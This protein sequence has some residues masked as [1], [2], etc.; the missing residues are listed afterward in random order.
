MSFWAKLKAFI[1]SANELDTGDDGHVVPASN[2]PIDSGNSCVDVAPVPTLDEV[3]DSLVID[4][5]SI[6]NS[7][8]AGNAAAP[9]SAVQTKGLMMF[10]FN[11]TEEELRFI[12]QAVEAKI[13]A[14]Q[15]FLQKLI[16]TANAQ[17]QIQ[18]GQPAAAAN[19]NPPVGEADA[20]PVSGDSADAGAS[21][22][23][24]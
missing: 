15:S 13:A 6:S 10:N 9:S 2:S 22:A 11:H 24:A 14:L 8:N 7:I 21:T 5:S 23:T 16:T 19:A 1:G 18:N 3:G 17:A 4:L 12:I 20:A